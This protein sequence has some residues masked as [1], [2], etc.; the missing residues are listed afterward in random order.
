MASRAKKLVA[1]Y[2]GELQSASEPSAGRWARKT[3]FLPREDGGYLRRITRADGTVESERII[4]ADSPA[5]ARAATG[6]SQARFAKVLGVS[7]RTLQEWEQ[8]RRH[9]SPAARALLLIAAKRPDVFR[10]VLG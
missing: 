6:L 8:G 10:E 5:A 4:A 1:E 3:E 2:L 7:S 9:P